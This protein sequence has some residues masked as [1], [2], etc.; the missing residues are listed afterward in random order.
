MLKKYFLYFILL[1]SLISLSI[2][3]L[4]YTNH[5]RKIDEVS[6]YTE[7]LLSAESKKL[8]FALNEVR[9]DLN[10][11]SNK[12]PTHNQEHIEDDF[13][14]FANQKKRYNQMRF[15][16]NNGMEKI[17]INFDNKSSTIVSKEKLQNKKDRYYFL[18]SIGL[19]KNNIYISPLDLNLEHGSI[20]VPVKPML[21]FSTPVYNDNN[22]KIGILV[23]N[24]L[25]D[26]ILERIRKVRN[27][28]FGELSLLNTNGYYF[29]SKDSSQEWA[30]M[31]QNKEDL[32]FKSQF[33]EVW[34][35]INVK[36]EGSFKDERG[37]YFFKTVNLT[38]SINGENKIVCDDSVWKTVLLVPHSYFEN[39]IFNDFM[40]YL[41]TISIITII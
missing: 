16:D 15:I 9:T 5:N 39:K 28:F 25:A 20:E 8:T 31:F 38:K 3:L 27:N 33:K 18:K 6:T 37:I 17:R 7:N 1:I 35:K 36:N 41:P 24:Y 29:I 11:L 40:N 21:R 34:Q 19:K 13:S 14:H 26:G 32:T 10:Y 23:L 30:F 22:E 2:V 12:F 4:L